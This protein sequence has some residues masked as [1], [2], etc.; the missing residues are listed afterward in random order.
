MTLVR[1]VA[2]DGD[3]MRPALI[4]GDRVLVLRTGRYR[5][6][7]VVALADPRTG[8]TIIKRVVATDGG[9]VVVRGDNAA[10]ST[11][12]RTF[13]PVPRAAVLGRAVY[14]YAPIHRAARLR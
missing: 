3:S 4:P 11:D 7:H 12:S 6:G 8:R 13:G 10:A 5:P 9:E 1:F 2:V 14:R